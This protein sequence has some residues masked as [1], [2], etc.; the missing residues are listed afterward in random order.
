MAV[1]DLFYSTSEQVQSGEYYE[2]IYITNITNFRIAGTYD[3]LR[4]K[5]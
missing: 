3:E 5:I 1:A 4:K 2:Q